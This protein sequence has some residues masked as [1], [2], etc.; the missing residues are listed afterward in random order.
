MSSM[1]YCYAGL[2]GAK[3]VGCMDCRLDGGEGRM[4]PVMM[5]V[6]ASGQ[7]LR[8]QVMSDVEGNGPGALR[9]E[10]EACSNA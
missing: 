3:I 4:G 7:R 6:T 5:V 2:V 10:E 9:I 8:V 1:D